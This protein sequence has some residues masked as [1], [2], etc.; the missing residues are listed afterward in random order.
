MPWW[1]TA[2]PTKSR[3]ASWPR[4][5]TCMTRA[6]R[7]SAS[8]PPTSCTGSCRNA[9]A[10]AHYDEATRLPNRARLGMLL[11]DALLTSQREGSL[12]T[13]C[14]LDIDH[15]KAINER[16]GHEAGDRL[17]AALAVRV[18]SSLRTWAGGDDVAARV[19]GD[20]FALLLRTATL[21][22]SHHAV[23]RVLQQIALPCDI[24]TADG[25]LSVTASIGAT[26]YPHD[27]ADGEALLR[28]ADQ[29]MYGAKQSGRNGYLF[30]DAELDRRTR[31]ASS[32]SAACRRPS[33]PPSSRCT[34]SRRSTWPAAV[35][36]APRRCCA[37]TI[38]SMA[39][40]RR[41]SSCRWWSTP[42]WASILADGCWRRAWPSWRAGCARGW[43]SR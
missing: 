24:G 19:G 7:A 27:R 4:C 26:V 2:M 21:R 32:P 17:L 35:R 28:H 30:F 25:P 8:R 39:W 3:C 41:A 12:L 13:V 29:A 1:P 20:E 34:T 43:T 18:Q 6:R 9:G 37:G 15:F 23:Q 38:R 11:Q 40:C 42:A 33:T 36:W 5:A 14:H 22:E 31:T 10:P 16:H